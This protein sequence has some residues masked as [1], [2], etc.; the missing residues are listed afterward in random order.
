VLLGRRPRAVRLQLLSPAFTQ[1]LQSSKRCRD[2][3]LQTPEKAAAC[4]G[5]D[6]GSTRARGGGCREGRALLAQGAAGRRRLQQQE[7]SFPGAGGTASRSQEGM[8]WGAEGGGRAVTGGYHRLRPHLP[9]VPGAQAKLS[10]VEPI[11]QRPSPDTGPPPASGGRCRRL[12]PA[13]CPAAGP[14]C[15]GPVGTASPASPGR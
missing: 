10:Q 8:R 9:T 5:Q 12:P 3:H 11:L 14:R 6:A 1:R 4:R 13:V 7:P 2:G 15:S